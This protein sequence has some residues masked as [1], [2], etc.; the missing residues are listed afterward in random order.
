MPA[1]TP[2]ECM[3]SFI[4]AMVRRD[5]AA[6]L[7]LLANDVALF[8]SNGAALWGKE[9]FESAMT[10]NWKQVSNY[11]YS[12]LDSIWLAESETVAS[13]IYTFSWSGNAGGKEVSGSGRGTRV[14]LKA[15]FGWLIAHEH[16]STGA[17]RAT[18]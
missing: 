10:V 18:D 12:T 15:G 4:D 9:A 5:M 8:Y 7:D 14:F 1:S 11:K 17:W 13:V 6:A 2:Q 3:T 16:L